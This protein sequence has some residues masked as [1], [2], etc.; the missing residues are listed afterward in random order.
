MPG[1]FIPFLCAA[2]ALSLV[3]GWLRWRGRVRPLDPWEPVDVL[4]VPGA[5]VW[6]R[7]GEPV[8]SPALARRVEAAV[9]AWHAGR[10]P[11]LLFT[12][13]DTG[14]G[15]AEAVVAARHARE[16][17]VPDGAISVESTS[18]TTLENFREALGQVP[19]GA[20]LAVLSDSYHVARSVGW[21]HRFRPD[22]TLVGVGA[23]TPPARWLRG[24][25][26]ELPGLLCLLFSGGCRAAGR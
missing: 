21:A 18:Q 7:A 5:R 26:R 1:F 12:G 3:M 9:A 8:A 23:A 6:I 13:G 16:L 11:R 20:R 15:T 19:H 2:V 14:A 25:L 17:G 4:L 24:A 22:L 10:T